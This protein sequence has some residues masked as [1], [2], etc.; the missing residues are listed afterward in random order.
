[1]QRLNTLRLLQDVPAILKDVLCSIW[2]PTLAVQ[3]FILVSSRS[4]KWWNLRR[5]ERSANVAITS[6]IVLLRVAGRP[7]RVHRWVK[8]SSTDF[9]LQWRKHKYFLEQNEVCTLLLRHGNW[10]PSTMA[11]PED[12]KTEKREPEGTDP[13]MSSTLLLS[14]GHPVLRRMTWSILLKGAF[15]KWERCNERVGEFWTFRMVQLVSARRQSC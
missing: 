4:E 5:N 10:I 7:R 11:D 3:S 1:M 13:E 14:T 15:R 12:A 2:L 6:Q 9:S 8:I